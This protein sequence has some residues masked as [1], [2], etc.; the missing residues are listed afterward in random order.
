MPTWAVVLLVWGLSSPVA[1]RF[2]YRSGFLATADPI[3]FFR[4][5]A[6]LFI[7][8]ALALAALAERILTSA[9]SRRE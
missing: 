7:A 9:L 8:P 5:P 4:I 6:V 2:A 1:F 3:L